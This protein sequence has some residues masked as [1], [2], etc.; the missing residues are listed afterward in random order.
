LKE[1]NKTLVEYWGSTHWLASAHIASQAMERSS[2]RRQE[3]E[4]I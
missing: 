2:Q 1:H 3:G 4:S